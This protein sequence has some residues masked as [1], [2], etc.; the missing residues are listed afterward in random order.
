MLTLCQR[1]REIGA[2]LARLLHLGIG[3]W[4]IGRWPP[5]EGVA[6]CAGHNVP[7]RPGE[8]LA[9]MNETVAAAPARKRAAEI[10]GAV[11]ECPF[12]HYSLSWARG[13]RTGGAG[14]LCAA[15]ETIRLL[16]LLPR[17]AFVV[18]HRGPPRHLHVLACRI[19]PD[20]G[21]SAPGNAAGRLL[22]FEVDEE[23]FDRP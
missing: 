1:R 18:A 19:S 16:D 17:Q 20:D 3:P 22:D 9:A 15:Q 6:W 2:D 8:A 12:W 5:R 4:L 7:N 10:R 23:D 21:R 14:V 11:P 13:D